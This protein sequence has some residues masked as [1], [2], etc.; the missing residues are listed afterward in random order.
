VKNILL[1]SAHPDDWEIGMGGTAVKLIASGAHL[2]SIVLTDGRRSPNPFQ[3]NP[4]ELAKL[5]K[6]EAI[7]AA[8]VIGVQETI[9]FDLEDLKS[10]AN[11]A[12][13]G[14]KLEEVIVSSRP[15]EVYALHPELDRHASHRMSGKLV[16]E[17]IAR[18]QPECTVWAY[19][20]WGLF[21]RWDRFE[22]VSSTIAKKIQAIQE[23]KSQIASIPYAEG[24]SGLNRWR[25]IFSDP[26]Q[27][28]PRCTFAEV[29]LRI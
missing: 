2:I 3:L 19:E 21:A 16:Q 27:S 5:R 23:H 11:C 6:E 29:F 28:E 22:D 10:E 20:V 1:I 7:R 9:F 12:T 18:I 8:G 26:E 14:K 24:V 15:A 25:A 17:T 4:G 13:A